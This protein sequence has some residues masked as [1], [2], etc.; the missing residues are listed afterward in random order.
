MIKFSR[1]N[2]TI[3]SYE[4][5]NDIFNT[6]NVGYSTD[7]NGTET[8]TGNATG[9]LRREC[10]KDKNIEEYLAEKAEIATLRGE[11]NEKYVYG[12]DYELGDYVTVMTDEVQTVKQITEVKEV[13][14]HGRSMIIPVFGTEKENPLKRILKG[15]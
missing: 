8:V 10:F 12:K 2:R 15:E 13:Y 7:E 4:L 11:A 1:K 6:Y 14:E 9:F 3:E 5:V